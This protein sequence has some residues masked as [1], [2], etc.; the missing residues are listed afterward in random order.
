M[1]LFD[2]IIIGGGL[3]GSSTAVHLSNRG[4]SVLVLEKSSHKSIIPCAGGM[5]A[6]M[7]NFLPIDIKKIIE[8]E[9]KR[10]HFT[11]ESKDKVIA[12]LTGESPF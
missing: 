7:K 3:S 8:T 6:T 5:A 9:V 11:Y 10:V 2:V 4:Y 1:K 12:E